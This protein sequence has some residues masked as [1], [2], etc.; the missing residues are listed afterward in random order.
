MLKR[1][2]N[3]LVIVSILAK[4]QVR[5]SRQTALDFLRVSLA[6]ILG[7]FLVLQAGRIGVKP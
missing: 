5:N 3:S 6:S 1:I 7:L 4:S 2:R